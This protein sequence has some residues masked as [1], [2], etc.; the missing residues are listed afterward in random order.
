LKPVKT[1][2]WYASQLQRNLLLQKK[3]YLCAEKNV[4]GVKAAASV[5]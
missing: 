4:V 5:D 1:K 2:N 3:R